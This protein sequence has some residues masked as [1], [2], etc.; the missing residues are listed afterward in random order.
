MWTLISD[1]KPREGHV[2]LFR[3]SRDESIQAGYYQEGRQNNQ[4]LDFYVING[5]NYD[6]DDP[7][8]WCEVPE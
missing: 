2:V 1:R 4:W 7:I 8:S 3:W 6:G 5:F